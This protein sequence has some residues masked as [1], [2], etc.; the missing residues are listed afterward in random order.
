MQRVAIYCRLSKE[1]EEKRRKG[2]D[3]ESIQ[4]QKLLLMEYAVEHGWQIHKVYTDDDY[5][6]LYED[7]PSFKQMIEDAESRKFEIV[8]C[9]SQARFA[10]EMEQVE[11]YIHKY[12]ILWGIRFVS[13]IDHVDT[14]IKGNKKS[15]Q[16]NG[17]V[18]EWYCE[19]LSENVKAALQAKKKNGQYLGHWC[20]YGYEL[21]KDDRHKIVVDPVAAEVVGEIYSLYLSGYGISSIANI[22]TERK[23]LTPTVYKQSKGKKYFNP[24]RPQ[25][26]EKY[27]V[28]AVNTVRRILRDQTYIGH[29]IQGREK[30]LSYKSK[31]VVPVPE[32][33][34]IVVKDN[35]EPIIDEET[36]YKVQNR[37]GVKSSCFKSNNGD[38]VYKPHL[39]AGKVRCMDCGAAMQKNH[40]K[41]NVLYLRCGLAVK[42]KN[43]E[44]SLHTIRLDLLT[45]AVEERIR[46]LTQMYISDENNAA[47]LLKLYCDNDDVKL[48]IEKKKVALE[49]IKR[50]RA[51][52]S[53]GLTSA[54]MDK[55][56]G[57]LTE[58]NFFMLQLDFHEQLKN[59]EHLENEIKAEIERLENKLLQGG[60]TEIQIEKYIGFKTLTQEMVNDFIDYIEIGE[61]HKDTQKIK[62]HWMF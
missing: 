16:I 3:S 1:D 22:L 19:D 32:R 36:F 14:E 29:L 18:N 17:L 25:Y 54:Y 27:G 5:S 59:F 11:K 40:G 49:D 30:K 39:F 20:T 26:S 57:N 51:N 44:C 21:D 31:K 24:A 61:K 15:R 50:N 34:W 7:R 35:H 62:I 37:I 53:N 58:Q 8:L 38:K 41:K 28:W 33:E 4:N 56:K 10:R 42:T 23:Y 55:I 2:D 12:F 9:K 48:E 60:T 52:I 6:G 43:K 46:E 13:V 47:E 45:T